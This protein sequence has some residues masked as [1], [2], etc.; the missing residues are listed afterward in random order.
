MG[1][2]TSAQD[3]AR[4]LESVSS[5]LSRAVAGIPGLWIE[6]KE[7]ALAVHYR[8]AAS[9]DVLRARA[10]LDD[11]LTRF[12]G[13]FRIQQGKSVWEILPWEL[14]DKGT[15]VRCE[16]ASIATRALAIYIGDDQ[17]DEPAFSALPDG[18][19]VRVG[20]GG[21]SYAR[22]RLSGIP[23]VRAFLDKLRTEFTR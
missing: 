1:I 17:V 8:D 13:R 4:W 18:L 9:P 19:T 10:L 11:V 21:Q 12:A 5:D 3:A 15:A 2:A 14:G 16:L 22:Y 6:D 23:Q 20:R 7:F